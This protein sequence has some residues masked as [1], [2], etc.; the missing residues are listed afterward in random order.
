MIRSSDVAFGVCALSVAL[1]ART[2][3]LREA[4][5]TDLAIAALRHLPGDA[6]VADGV[7]DEG[8]APAQESGLA[9]MA[10]DLVPAAAMQRATQ[11]FATMRRAVAAT[12]AAHQ[13]TP[14]SG[15]ITAAGGGHHEATPATMEGQSMPEEIQDAA[16]DAGNTPAVP[17]ATPASAAPAAPEKK[18]SASGLAA[19]GRRARMLWQG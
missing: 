3:Q 16:Q 17:A 11:N 7:I 10:R 13:P 19:C 5:R 9:Q 14:V 2:G 12:M 15:V 4:D 8:D 1:K 18:R 6:G